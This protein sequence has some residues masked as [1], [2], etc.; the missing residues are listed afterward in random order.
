M[1]YR[2]LMPARSL[3]E[4]LERPLPVADLGTIDTVVVCVV[5]AVTD[6]VLEPILGMGAGRA[7]ARDA[8]DDINSQI[9]AVGLIE[10]R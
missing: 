10:N 5:E 3:F 8:V 1:T 7:E 2:Q 9:E 6:L 4:R